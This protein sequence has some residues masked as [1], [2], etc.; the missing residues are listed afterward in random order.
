MAN[1][2]KPMGMDRTLHSKVMSK[3]DQG[4]EYEVRQWIQQLTGEDVGSGAVEVE[5]KLRNGQILCRLAKAVYEGTSN[6]PPAAHGYK[7]KSNT[8]AAPFKQMENIEVFLKAVEKYGV[9]SASLFPT[10][11]LF[12]GR[13]MAMVISTILQFGSEAQR[14]GFNGPTCGSKPT[15]RHEVHFTQE[16]LRAGQGIIGLQAGTNKLASQSGMSMGAVR[17]ISD[18]R[19]DD[20]SKEGQGIVGLQAGSNKGAS[21]AGMSMGSVRHIADIR[22]DDA[23]RES[24]GIIGLQAGSN[25]G[26]TQAGMSMGAVRHIADI[27][28]DD[29]S[30]EGAGVIGL[31]AG[32]NKGASQAGM[33]MGA[34]R[35]I[36]DI[37]VDDMSQDS[38]SSINLQYGSNQGANQQGMSYGGRRDI[39]GN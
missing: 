1:R 34:Q 7:I 35:H 29:A 36:A 19:V 26:A 38:Q 20:M 21:Q 25:K 6:L 2:E 10:A 11:D 37:K 27:R 9:P 31:Q 8:M 23:S 15:E 14:H 30:R 28:A 16:Q 4:A 39:M 22:A 5:K 3:Y 33:S 32:S 24:S 12:E 13:N 18:I 17:H